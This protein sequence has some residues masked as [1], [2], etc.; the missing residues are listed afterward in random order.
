[1]IDNNSILEKVRSF[2][3]KEKIDFLIVNAT[4]EYLNEYIDIEQNSRYILTGF[5]GST[6]DALVSQKEVFLFVDGRYHLQAEEETDEKTIT[7]VKVQMNKSPSVALY[8]KISE[9]S[10]GLQKIGIIATKTNCASYSKLFSTLADKNFEYK[11]LHYDPIIQLANIETERKFFSLKF[12]SEEITGS[13]PSEK[14]ERLIKNNHKNDIDILIL[15]KLDEIAYLTNLRGEQIPYNSSFKAKAIINSEKC[16]LFADIDKNNSDIEKKLGINF[17]IEEEKE[18]DDGLKQ[19]SKIHKSA[20]IAYKPSDMNLSICRKIEQLN[21]K[22]IQIKNN[23]LASMKSVKNQAEL[24][25]MTECFLKTDIVI[26]RVVSWL[27]QEL[28]SNHKVSEKDLSDKIKACFF[29][30]GAN[31]LSFETIAASGA[32]TAF[33]HYTKANPDKF[34]QKGELVLVDCGAYFQGGYATDITRTFLAGG[35]KTLADKEQKTLYTAVLK[36]FLNGINYKIDENTT[37]FDIDKK[38]R[39]V[40]DQNKPEGFNFAHGTG[41]GIGICVHE[42][43]PSLSPSEL[44]KTK[45]VPGMCFTIEPGLYCDKKGGVRI[46]NTVTIIE[47]NGKKQ[48][49]SLTKA[50]LDDNLI[51]YSLLNQQEK[52]WLEEYTKN[53]MG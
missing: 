4:D 32:N 25:H 1:M 42:S 5:T 51:D 9:C 52:I 39:D 22:L 20:V 31:A 11:E 53:K 41:H 12:I 50:N 16:F 21:Q 10:D 30:E 48:I 44:S 23:S 14:L 3:K 6:G 49:K 43:P 33:I 34:I 29:E 47:K 28:E 15:T 19:I 26:S 17:E 13:A 38:V 27:N 24:Q 35:Q 37:G 36:A 18:F 40:I 8:E 45:L 46:E 2:M 7:V